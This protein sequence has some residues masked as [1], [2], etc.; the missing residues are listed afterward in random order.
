MEQ[1]LFKVASGLD[2]QQNET[3]FTLIFHKME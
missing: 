2:I 3:L 1:V